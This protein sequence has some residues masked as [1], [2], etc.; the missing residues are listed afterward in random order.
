[1]DCLSS[2]TERHE[3]LAW[4]HA[5]FIQHQ[6]PNRKGLRPFTPNTKF[7]DPHFSHSEDMIADIEIEKMGHVT[8]TTPF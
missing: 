1:V 3:A 5:I 6:P 7:G 2:G 4:L 8:L